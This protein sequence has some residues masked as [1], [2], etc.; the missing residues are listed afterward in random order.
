MLRDAAATSLRNGQRATEIEGI[1]IS[2]GPNGLW[3]SVVAPFKDY[4]GWMNSHDM[5][6]HVKD[7]SFNAKWEQVERIVL[8]ALRRAT[9]LDDLAGV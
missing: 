6:F 9:I 2:D 5:V 8:P 1:S 7:G 4:L 3:I